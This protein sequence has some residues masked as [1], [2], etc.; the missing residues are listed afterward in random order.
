M[1]HLEIIRSKVV[2]EK[3]TWII[4]ESF[5]TYNIFILPVSL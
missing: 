3:E 2:P 1:L 4:F 5:H